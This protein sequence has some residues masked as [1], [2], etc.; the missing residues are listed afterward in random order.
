MIGIIEELERERQFSDNF[1]EALFEC[2]PEAV[3]LIPLGCAALLCIAALCA[4]GVIVYQLMFDPNAMDVAS[5][6]DTLSIDPNKWIP[7]S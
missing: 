5:R 6:L 4:V 3:E 1:V 2:L 7:R